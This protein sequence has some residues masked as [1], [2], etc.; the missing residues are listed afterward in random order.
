MEIIETN[1]KRARDAETIERK[2]MYDS[3]ILWN[4]RG[5]I[6]V[7]ADDNFCTSESHRKEYALEILGRIKVLNAEF[8]KDEELRGQK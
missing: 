5:A 7:W 6:S 4:L 1:L 2:N 3:D 8:K